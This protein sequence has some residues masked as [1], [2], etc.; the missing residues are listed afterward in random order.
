MPH[1]ARTQKI[2]VSTLSTWPTT[3]LEE[4]ILCKYIAKVNI[5]VKN[6][7]TRAISS[8]TFRMLS[9]F[10]H[11]TF[12][13]ANNNCM[14]SITFYS[15]GHTANIYLFKVNGR[16]TRKRCEICSK[17]TIKTQNGVS[18]VVLVFF[19]VTSEHISHLFLV[20]LQLVLNK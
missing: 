12:G 17:L 20:S 6:K 5:Q 14:I 4:A 1:D 2:L 19:I 3:S 9:H 8:I 18:D 7:N 13:Y 15:A 16:N 10:S 11:V